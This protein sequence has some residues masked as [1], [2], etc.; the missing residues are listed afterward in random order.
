MLLFSTVLEIN[1]KMN[2]E[3]FKSLIMEWNA[4]SPHVENI[5]SG[6]VWKDE[7][8]YR[9]G[10][11]NLWIAVE[12]YPQQSTVAVRFEKIEKD[13]IVWN[14]DYVMN[15]RN[16]KLAIRLD[17]SYTE[18]ALLGDGKFS[19]P[20]II[21]LLIEKGY[22][23][24]DASLP[25]TLDPIYI[26]EENL[27]LLADVVLGKAHYKYPVIYV[28]KN[29]KGE[30]PVDI[31]TLAY[32]LKGLAHVL[33]QEDSSTDLKIKNMCDSKNEYK[34]AVGIYFPNAAVKQKR[35][36]YRRDNGYDPVMLELIIQNVL[37][38][39]NVQMVKPLFTWQGVTNALLID[40][41]NAQSQERLQAENARK[42]AEERANTLEDELNNKED[43]IRQEAREA[44]KS[45]TDDLLK[46]ADEDIQKLKDQ[47]AELTRIN[48]SLQCENL[49][50]RA[51]VS[52]TENIPVL[53]YGYEQ[54]FYQGEIKDMILS[55][56]NDALPNLV[57]HRR[58]YDVIKDI[59]ESNDY[60]KLTEKRAEE[61]K[62]LLKSYD[63]MTGKLRLEL[64]SFGFVLS[65]EGKH[66]KVTYMGD[67]RYIETLS[68]TPS[69]WRAGKNI[70]G[71]MTKL[72]Y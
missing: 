33:V 18:E 51:K 31:E 17:R 21:K 45:E 61:I 28:S 38:Y 37:Q 27:Q 55:V 15:F 48:E 11:D 32:R 13:G 20:Y 68:K 72:A 6:F 50:L 70:V 4:D 36:F 52:D 42:Q 10:T 46:I 22:L 47:I 60:Q 58:L 40:R 44:A 65:E 2:R 26:K 24:N 7:K 62:R 8:N 9:W 69:D 25:I 5:I 57:D 39:C 49:G 1:E 29:Y 16:M 63:G 53:F 19:S 23:K 64:E 59:V 66:Y 54:E 35:L 56:L 3:A 41:V 12:D 43:K 30:D 67:T 14:T 71:K 34:G